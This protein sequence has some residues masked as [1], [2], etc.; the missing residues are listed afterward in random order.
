VFAIPTEDL[1]A[2]IVVVM[3]ASVF[4]VLASLAVDLGY[5]AF[6]PRMRAS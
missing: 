1:P 5:A 2:I 4:V 3:M 6:D